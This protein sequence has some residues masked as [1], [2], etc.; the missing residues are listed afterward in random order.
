MGVVPSAL[1]RV[2]YD[3]V[4]CLYQSELLGCIRDIGDVSVRMEF[5]CLFPVGFT[6]P[7]R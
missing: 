6:D 4:C 1:L 5:E 7:A 3:L 2:G